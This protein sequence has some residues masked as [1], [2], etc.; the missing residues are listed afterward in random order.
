L[1]L[2]EIRA[3]SIML[4]CRSGG[5]IQLTERPE[6]PR[7]G[8]GEHR[9]EPDRAVEGRDSYP[10]RTS[11]AVWSPMQVSP[12]ARRLAVLAAAG[13]ALVS[14]AGFLGF[15][16]G[17]R[18]VAW[19][20]RQPQYQLAFAQ[21]GLDPKPPAWFRGGGPAF[22]AGVKLA[23]GEADPIPLLEVG[24]ERLARAFK[25]DPW[26]DDVQIRYGPGAITA[27]IRYREPVAYVQLEG[28]NQVIVDERGTILP[29]Q[30]VDEATSVLRSLIKITGK[31]LRPPA[32][33]RAGEIWTSV[34]GSTDRAVLAAA[35][36]AGF[37]RIEPRRSDSASC[38]ALR[39]IEINVSDFE[40]RGL[41]LFNAEGAVVWWRSPPEGE[42]HTEP[43]AAEKWTLLRVWAQGNE[44]RSLPEGDYWSFATKTLQHTC[45]HSGKHRVGSAGGIGDRHDGNTSAKPSHS[46]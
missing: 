40:R 29:T 46:G 5:G 26:V 44:H 17:R 21:I 38:G 3:F 19:L 1:R 39:V 20:H 18:A 16:G 23:S 31:S 32:G 37:L 13:C 30:D 45:P 27:S 2:V 7:F 25:N 8:T 24:P 11:L 36:L 10:P 28:G 42:S 34:D 22:L 15:W 9:G 4:D 12:R 43:I 6:L 35:K 33:A 41:F 14:L